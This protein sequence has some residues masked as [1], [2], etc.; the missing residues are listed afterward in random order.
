MRTSV[1]LVPLPRH[2]H[3]CKVQRFTNL[4]ILHRPE[5]ARDVRKCGIV[6][7]SKAL[8]PAHQRDCID[9]RSPMPIGAPGLLSLGQS[10]QA[11]VSAPTMSM[12]NYTK[13]IP[14][15]TSFDVLS[16]IDISDA[17]S[18]GVVNKNAMGKKT[19]YDQLTPALIPL[20]GRHAL[21]SHRL[22]WC[23][24]R[25]NDDATKKARE[26][27]VSFK[28]DI[29]VAMAYHNKFISTRMRGAFIMNVDVPFGLSDYMVGEERF[30][31]ITFPEAQLTLCVKL[32]EAIKAYDPSRAFVLVVYALSPDQLSA[33]LWVWTYTDHSRGDPPNLIKLRT[34][35]REIL[36][37][38]KRSE[39]HMYQIQKDQND[40]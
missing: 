38:T 14:L 26:C 25:S 15:H 19:V 35:V 32:Q 17:L 6:R 11:S 2:A 23:N 36:K 24:T 33:A 22:I 28:S 8:W 34:R 20:L 21:A 29:P 39:R 27:F 13:A 12:N 16:G 40:P 4:S 10:P 3:T 18:Q 1:G 9:Q 31:W 37:D 7:Q 5:S 30:N